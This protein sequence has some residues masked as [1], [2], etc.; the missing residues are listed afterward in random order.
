MNKTLLITTMLMACVSAKGIT[1]RWDEVHAIHMN[2]TSTDVESVTFADTATI[3][4]ICVRVKESETVDIYEGSYLSDEHDNRYCLTRVNEMDSQTAQVLLED[5]KVKLDLVYQPVKGKADY[6]DIM[7]MYYVCDGSVI[8][9]HSAIK[10]KCGSRWSAS[11]P[12]MKHEDIKLAT[13]TAISGV[14]RG[15]SPSLGFGT[16][17]IYDDYTGASQY[18][19]VNKD[20]SFAFNITNK[21]PA[22]G[23]I[24]ANTAKGKISIPY[25]ADKDGKVYMDISDMATGNMRVRYM[26]GDN[27]SPMPYSHLLSADIHPTWWTPYTYLKTRTRASYKSMVKAKMESELCANSYLADKYSLSADELYMLN[28]RTMQQF[29]LCSV[30]YRNITG[31]PL[32]DYDADA[33]LANPN[34]KYIFGYNRLLAA[35]HGNEAVEHVDS[36]KADAPTPVLDALVKSYAGKYVQIVFVNTSR[37]SLERLSRLRGLYEDMQADDKVKILFVGCIDLPNNDRLVEKFSLYIKDVSLINLSADE[38]YRLNEEIGNYTL[39]GTTRTIGT[40]GKPLPKSWNIYDETSF[41][42]DMKEVR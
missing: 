37:K 18:A 19:H 32:G 17:Y 10:D 8:G 2:V 27:L 29:D 20:G 14:I 28:L 12:D 25:I 9:I 6:L 42:R 3:V 36:I 16:L 21:I 26:S 13:P 35:V 5:G 30:Y 4:S 15:Y 7:D 1:T 11:L 23:Y 38:Y 22:W 31:L 24:Y 34:E 33:L 40:D 41:R 39:A